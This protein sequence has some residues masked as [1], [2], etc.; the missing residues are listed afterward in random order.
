MRDLRERSHPED[1]KIVCACCRLSAGAWLQQ[2]SPNNDTLPPT[3]VRSA[4]RGTAGRLQRVGGACPDA[5]ATVGG[6]ECAYQAT[7]IWR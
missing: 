5:M 4:A 6:E 7:R 1:S 2:D 3:L